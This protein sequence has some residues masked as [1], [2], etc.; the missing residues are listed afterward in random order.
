MTRLLR[1]LVAAAVAMFAV[2][3]A[4]AEEAAW[5]ALRESGT[6]LIVR[7]AETVPGIGDPPGFRLDDCAT[8]RNLSETG[9]AQ[10]VAMGRKLAEQ[11]VAVTR[12]ESSRWCRTADTA[13][14]A[15]PRLQV[16][17]LEALNSF[18]EDRTA[19]AGQ[20]R[21]LSARIADWKGPGVLVLV[22]HQVNISALTGRPTAVG[23]AVVLRPAGGEVRVLGTIRF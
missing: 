22:T 8:Q 2:A 17:F 5:K 15:F 13:R 12:V 7:H 4:S 6:V 3:H 19:A 10:A 20:T 18:F 14:L 16:V 21:A 9:R 11:V 1:L 23:E